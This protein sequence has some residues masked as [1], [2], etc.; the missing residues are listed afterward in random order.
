MSAT[1]ISTQKRVLSFHVET[2]VEHPT[3]YNSV[4]FEDMTKFSIKTLFINLPF[5]N[6]PCGMF[7][8]MR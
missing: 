6:E 3:T 8:V 5:G 1:E 7:K 4:N 2:H